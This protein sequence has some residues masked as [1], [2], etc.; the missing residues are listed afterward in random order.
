MNKKSICSNYCGI[1][2]ING[3]CPVAIFDS[4]ASYSVEPESC[5]NCAYNKGCVDCCFLED[6]GTCIIQ[7]TFGLLIILLSA[8]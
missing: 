3:N 5:E 4:E 6:T 1:N 2:C 8:N 7:E